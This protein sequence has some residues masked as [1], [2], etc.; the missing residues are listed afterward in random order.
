M[1]AQLFPFS[2]VVIPHPLQ[3]RYGDIVVIVAR[4]RRSA[5]SRVAVPRRSG[6]RP[7]VMAGG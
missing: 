1:S 5:D 2:S 6:S 3:V 7:I 4:R